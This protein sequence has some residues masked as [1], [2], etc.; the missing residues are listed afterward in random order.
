MGEAAR[1]RAR[2]QYSRPEFIRILRD[3]FRSWLP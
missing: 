1:R 2:T 3:C